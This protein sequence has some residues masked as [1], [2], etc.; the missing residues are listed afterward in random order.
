MICRNCNFIAMNAMNFGSEGL[1]KEFGI[2]LCC[3]AKCYIPKITFEET[4]E[5]TLRK[6]LG[7]CKML[8]L[9]CRSIKDDSKR[10]FT[11]GCI[12]CRLFQPTDY[13]NDGLIHY[14]NLTM[15]PAPCQA[16]C[17]YCTVNKV[18]TI[19]ESEAKRYEHL[20]SVL[21]LADERGV[22]A[23]NATWQVSSG[24]IAIHPYHD[25]IMKL[26]RGKGAV[27]YT[28]AMKY[29]EEIALNLHYNPM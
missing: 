15:Y 24:E 27:Y 5:E 21:E 4:P 10:C 1:D 19:T 13:Q 12:D 28:N 6:F 26:T 16:R 20:F 11:K 9:E 18:N 17:S 3:E 8:D 2:S 25:R 22:I 23:A 7:E 29:D 14:V